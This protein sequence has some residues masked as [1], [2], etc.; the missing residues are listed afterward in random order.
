M[1]DEILT[2]LT[3]DQLCTILQQRGFRAARSGPDD[4]PVVESATAGLAFRC[5]FRSKYA[6]N[7]EGWQDWTNSLPIHLDIALKDG[8]V[9]RWNQAWRF[10]RL[11]QLEDRIMLEMDISTT[12]GVTSRHLHAQLE[13]WDHLVRGLVAAIR[14]DRLAP[15]NALPA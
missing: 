11:R 15:D 12:G 8:F 4:A 10:G 9:E 3:T 2:F 5:H 13:I 1:S 7:D 6:G 14:N